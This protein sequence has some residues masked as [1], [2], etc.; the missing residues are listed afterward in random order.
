MTSQNTDTLPEREAHA[1]ASLLGDGHTAQDA[2]DGTW[3]VLRDGEDVTRAAGGGLI[4]A[5]ATGANL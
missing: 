2:G 3:R 5:P 4:S 1:A